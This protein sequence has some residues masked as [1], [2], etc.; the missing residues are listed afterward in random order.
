MASLSRLFPF[1]LFFLGVWLSQKSSVSLTVNHEPAVI[2]AKEAF[3]PLAASVN[4]GH[5]LPHGFQQQ[6]RPESTWPQEA[7]QIMDMNWGA[8]SLRKLVKVTWKPTVSLVLKTGVLGFAPRF[9][10][11]YWLMLLL[12]MTSYFETHFHV[13]HLAQ[14]L[15]SRNRGRWQCPQ[16]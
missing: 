4:P 12:K 5:R 7:T 14:K 9:L 16:F 15:Y 11:P 1:L 2:T 8:R 13:W 3:L 6:Q 10:S